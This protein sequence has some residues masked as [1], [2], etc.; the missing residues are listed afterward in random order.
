VFVNKFS[1]LISDLFLVA[2]VAY[3]ALRQGVTPRGLAAVGIVVV[4]LVGVWLLVRTGPSTYSDVAQV[5]EALAD[6]QPTLVEFYSN[7]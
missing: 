4:A 5:E 7:Y 1:L 6:G 3:L 2:L